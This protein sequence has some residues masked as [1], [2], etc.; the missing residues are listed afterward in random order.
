MAATALRQ[1]CIWFATLIWRRIELGSGIF[2]AVERIGMDLLD[3]YTS[4][5][6]VSMD[7]TPLRSSYGGACLDWTGFGRNV[8]Q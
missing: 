1:R 3:G 6:I 7:D 8:E 5:C 2:G 4:F